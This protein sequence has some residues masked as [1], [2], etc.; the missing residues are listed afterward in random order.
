MDKELKNYTGEE[1]AEVLSGELQRLMRTYSDVTNCMTILH[2]IQNELEKRKIENIR[3]DKS[4][5]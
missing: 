4:N 3:K 2:T 1:L 5:G